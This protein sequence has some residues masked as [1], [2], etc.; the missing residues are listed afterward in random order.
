MRRRAKGFVAGRGH[1]P[2]EAY[3]RT[4]S[5]V[6][7]VDIVE[8]MRQRLGGQCGE[9]QTSS[10]AIWRVDPRDHAAIRGEQRIV[11]RECRTGLAIER[12]LIDVNEDGG[13]V[14]LR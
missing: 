13:A 11:L 9:V 6:G 4:L 1:G 5:A 8:R 7:P 14:D 10:R 3:R 2:R 12:E